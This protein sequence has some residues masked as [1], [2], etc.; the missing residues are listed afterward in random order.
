MGTPGWTV[1]R[2]TLSLLPPRTTCIGCQ[3]HDDLE[4]LQARRTRY[5]GGRRGDLWRTARKWSGPATQRVYPSPASGGGEQ[6][7]T[8]ARPRGLAFR[9]VK[10]EECVSAGWTDRL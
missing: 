7:S 3:P 9:T 4:G 8:H 5:C 2:A 6:G 10:S 1:M